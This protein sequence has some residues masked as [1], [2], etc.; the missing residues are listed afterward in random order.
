MT[1]GR[2]V[3]VID[4]D[5]AACSQI[6]EVLGRYGFKVLTSPDPQAGFEAAKSDIPD[7]I[8]I[9][10]L[11]PGTNGLK[12]SKA[13]HA[14][15]SL[16]KVPVIMLLTHRGEL[17]PKY[18]V[19]IGVLDT[20]VKP[21]KDSEIIEKTKA[22]LGD[23]ASTEPQSEAPGEL[24][25][26]EEITP[27]NF[28]EEEVMAEEPELASMMELS[29][30]GGTGEDAEQIEQE[31]MNKM[32]KEGESDM[33]EKENPF[34]RKE[35]DDR[36]LFT[37]EADMFG[38]ELKKS[39]AEEKGLQED[40]D[41]FPE[42]DADLAYEPEKPASSVRRILLIA[43]SIVVGIGL[44]VGGYFFFTAGSK[45]APVEKQVVKVLPE[46]APA[47][48]PAAIPAEKPNVIPEIPVASE[49]KKS[50][51]TGAKE[52]KPQESLP[53]AETKKESVQKAEAEKSGKEAAPVAAA[54]E[55]KKPAAAKQPAGKETRA[56]V[57][58]KRAYYVQA[59]LFQNEAYATTM[60]D[61]LR[62]KGYTPSVKKITTKDNK[63]MFR[64]TAGTYPNFRKAVE[65]SETL[66]KLGL[67][68]IVH[69]Q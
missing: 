2:K 20:L 15:G 41:R 11:L 25:L 49:P 10:L 48:A 31:T 30:E 12:V 7:L 56:A 39:R 21:L 17:D 47:P 57:K 44:G 53:K 27:M 69:K 19:T 67:T 50:E 45:Q 32:T 24:S 66:N 4:D 16:E 28:H 26:E 51:I 6:E 8:F 64:V 52:A 61:K 23:F 1:A 58:G 46:P 55:E 62:E 68:T 43:A 18:T 22:L 29:G 59:G 63:V 40:D 14:V 35:D 3:L 5:A 42:D 33:P 65:I 54:S 13:I 38:E 34:D 36:D 9:N 37:D 60:A